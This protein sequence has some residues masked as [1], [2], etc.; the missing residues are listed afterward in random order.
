MLTPP[1]PKCGGR[2]YAFGKPLRGQSRP[3]WRGGGEDNQLL[4]EYIACV[5]CGYRSDKQ[6]TKPALH[7][8]QET[9]R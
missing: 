4:R 3:S 2:T 5:V 9:K 6:S 8:E 1:C 7:L